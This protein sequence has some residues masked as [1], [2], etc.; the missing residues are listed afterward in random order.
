M[1]VITKQTSI[2]NSVKNEVSTWSDWGECS[3]KCDEGVRTRIMELCEDQCELKE[4]N[5]NESEYNWSDWI[6][7]EC[8][9]TCGSGIA[10]RKHECLE[11]HHFIGSAVESVK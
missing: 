5:C 1:L 4:E 10:V 2:R 7:G 8:S 11:E 6:Q 3:K 9:K